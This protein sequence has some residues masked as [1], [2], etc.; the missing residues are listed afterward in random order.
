MPSEA[1][2][3]VVSRIDDQELD[4]A[5]NQTRKEIENRFDFKHSRRRASSPTGRRLRSFPT[6]R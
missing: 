5:L 4:N 6:T 1:S 2:F 3:D